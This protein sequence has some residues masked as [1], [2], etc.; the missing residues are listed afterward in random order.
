MKESLAPTGTGSAPRPGLSL[1]LFI[2][3]RTE[4]KC[5]IN[6]PVMLLRFPVS[7]FQQHVVFRNRPGTSSPRVM[8]LWLLVMGFSPFLFRWLGHFFDNHL[9]GIDGVF[10]IQLTTHSPQ[11]HPT[12]HT[13]LL[14]VSLG[15][16]VPPAPSLTSW[17]WDG[18][19][20]FAVDTQIQ[21]LEAKSIGPQC[22]LLFIQRLT[23]VTLCRSESCWWRIRASLLGNCLRH[24]RQ[25]IFFQSVSL[26]SLSSD[27]LPWLLFVASSLSSSTSSSLP[28]A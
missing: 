3:L 20:Y 21:S 1:T 12:P 19:P 13:F 5:R 17:S 18:S 7:P 15:S 11:Q 16:L 8:M 27:W 24:S 23:V 9:G 4:D 22:N 26:S 6:H 10:R 28:A 2:S 14:L 25:A